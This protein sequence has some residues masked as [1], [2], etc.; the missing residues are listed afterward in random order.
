MSFVNFLKQVGL[1]GFGYIV[2]GFLLLSGIYAYFA[3]G[4]N[5][6]G[7]VLAAI[8]MLLFFYGIYV[9]REFRGR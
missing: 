1:M 7:I 4:D 8:G 9:D 5:L 3:Q 6:I 2:G